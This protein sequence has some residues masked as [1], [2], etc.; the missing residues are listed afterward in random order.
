MAYNDLITNILGNAKNLGYL[1]PFFYG[2][3]FSVSNDYIYINDL[4][5]F[6]PI[7]GS[8]VSFL[9]RVNIL[10]TIDNSLKVIPAS[11]NNVVATFNFKFL[12]NDKDSGNLLKTIEAGAGYKFL[13]FKDP[14]SLYKEIIGY[15]S[16]YSILKN[17]KN[18]N[19]FNV[20][21]L[22]SIK[23]LMFNWRTSSFLDGVTVQSTV[24]NSSKSYKKYEFIYDDN[25]KTKVLQTLSNK[26]KINNFWF[27]KKN[28]DIISGQEKEFDTNDWS[29]NFIY[30]NEIPFNLSNTFDVYQA[31][32]RNS[33]IQN[34]KYKN[35][36]NTLKEFRANFSN[37]N[38]IQCRSMLFFLEK[39][40]G[41]RKFIYDFPFL[42]KK[43]KVFICTEW[44]HTF[45]FFDCHDISVKFIE[46]PNPN[47]IIDDIDS[48]TYNYYV[49]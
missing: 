44:N 15:V 23:S 36:S 5:S 20:K 14:S 32:Y 24:F 40:N 31:D 41:F 45:K 19:E 2:K 3:D 9:S 6:K 28:I 8:S 7:Y 42:L 29:K 27:A 46:D 49:I 1:N 30:E 37:L 17:S 22:S 4:S 47:I 16:D 10:N 25:P 18:L 12:L 13:K 35:N 21:I 11:E 43:N 26:N 38:T 39:K 48:S 34:S 33:F